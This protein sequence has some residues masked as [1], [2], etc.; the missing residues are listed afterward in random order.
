MGKLECVKGHVDQEIS[1]K[2]KTQV[3]LLKSQQIVKEWLTSHPFLSKDT[4]QNS[5]RRIFKCFV[6]KKQMTDEI[7]SGLPSPSA[8]KHC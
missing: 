5:F 7:A 8:L 2:I 1:K 3:I 6:Q 4:E